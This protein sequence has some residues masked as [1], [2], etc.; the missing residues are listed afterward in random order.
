MRLL[1]RIAALRVDF[2]V[3][4]LILVCACLY[5]SSSFMLTLNGS[6][7]LGSILLLLAIACLILPALSGGCIPNRWIKASIILWLGIFTIDGMAHGMRLDSEE[8]RMVLLVSTALLISLSVPSKL[9]FKTVNTIVVALSIFALLQFVLV[10]IFGLNLFFNEFT[11]FN[12]I[13]YKLGLLAVCSPNYMYSGIWYS[14]LSIFWEPGIFASILLLAISFQSVGIS[15]YKPKQIIIMS[16]ALITTFSTAGI[17]LLPIA[18]LPKYFRSNSKTS[19]LLCLIGLLVALALI[20]WSENI[21]RALISLNPTIFGKIA[22][23]DLLTASTRLEAPVIN[24]RL[25]LEDPV[26]G[27]GLTEASEAYAREVMLRA[28]V[29]AQTSTSTFY[30]A[31]YGFLGIALSLLPAIGVAR[32]KNLSFVQRIILITLLYMILNKE[33]HIF[34]LLFLTIPLMMLKME[35][36]KV[37]GAIDD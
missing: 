1:N 3:V 19:I 36:K 4:A 22:N 10:N 27:L 28:S 7:L 13:K 16:V 17:L 26:F 14:S 31:A 18:L 20:Y 6:M 2:S 32:L 15:E 25:F 12:S 30:M 29:D 33:T 37:G 34:D 9:F 5:N 24:L 21:V 35:N 8:M 23:L 11:S